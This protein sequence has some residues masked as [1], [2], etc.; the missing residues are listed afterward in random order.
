MSVVEL[1]KKYGVS[2]SWYYKWKKRRDKNGEEGLKP[3]VR[4]KPNM[5]NKVPKR[6]ENQ[7]LN[8]VKEYPTYGPERIEAELKGIGR[9]YHQ[10]A[11]EKLF[12]FWCC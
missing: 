5:P 11:R 1:C 4:G 9:I 2:R 8:F 12:F 3:K 7:I 10:V 6:I